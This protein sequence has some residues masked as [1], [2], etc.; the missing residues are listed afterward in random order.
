[1]SQRHSSAVVLGAGMSGLLAARALSG[2]VARV[3]LVERDALPERDESRKG[4]PQ[5][6]HAHGL[7]ASGYQAMDDY[8]PGI[9]DEFGA[10]GAP[11]G[12]SS[13]TSSGSSTDAGS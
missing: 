10:L 8:F 1:M 5:S 2:H 13:A 9:M 3:T 4:V 12:T 6:N 11:R 7:L